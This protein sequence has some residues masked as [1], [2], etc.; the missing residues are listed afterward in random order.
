VRRT[1]GGIAA[2]RVRGRLRRKPLT[3][4]GALHR[5]REGQLSFTDFATYTHN[6]WHRL[7]VHLYR[8]WKPPTGVDVED[9][10]QE[11]LLAAWQF[12]GTWDPER[13]VSLER[14]VVWNAS[15]KAKKQLHKLRGAKLSGSSDRNPSRAEALTTNGDCLVEVS[16]DKLDE[17]YGRAVDLA[18]SA[19]TVAEGLVLVRLARTWSVQATATSL[20]A[21]PTTRLGLRLG[22][23]ASARRFVKGVLVRTAIRIA[24]EP[25]TA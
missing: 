10:L 24:A 23:E 9:V 21:D 15:D 8:R 18:R 22:S 7:A 2:S 19:E 14:Y 1:E 5:L 20:Y 13:E 17:R 4:D 25:K 11:V 6:H 12:V 3:L 16:E